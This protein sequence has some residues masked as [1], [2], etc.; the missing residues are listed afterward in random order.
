[1]TSRVTAKAKSASV[2]ASSRAVTGPLIGPPGDRNETAFPLQTPAPQSPLHSVSP[3]ARK[4]RERAL[5]PRHGRH[6]QDFEDPVLLAP[7]Q[8][9][10]RPA[11][12]G[13]FGLGES[14]RRA[15]RAGADR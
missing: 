5:G 7:P 13:R 3:A 9:R 8:A 14:R 11:G 10:R 15:R 2:K 1:M 4:W 6:A 12:A